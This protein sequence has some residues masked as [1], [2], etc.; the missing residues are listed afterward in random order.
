MKRF[1]NAR[2]TCRDEVVTGED[3]RT[4][5]VSVLRLLHRPD[6]DLEVAVF[7]DGSELKLD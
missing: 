2:H 4:H 6:P 1:T 7:V 3:Q 5:V